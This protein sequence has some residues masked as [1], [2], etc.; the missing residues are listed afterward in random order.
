MITAEADL[1]ATLL[2]E[3][4]S[5]TRRRILATAERSFR[6]IGYQK[7]TVADIARA[8]RMSPANVYRFFESKKAINEAVVR[9]VMG[10]IEAMIADIACERRRPAGERIVAM[11]RALHADCLARCTDNPRMHEMCEAAMTES[12]DVCRHHVARI[13]D[14][15]VRVVEDGN[16]SG[17]FAVADPDTTGRCVHVALARYCHPLLVGQLPNASAPPVEAMADLLVAGLRARR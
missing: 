15:F 16:A 12:W 11:I 8:L 10:E 3:P 13:G 5:T 9:H 2:D 6:E 1:D 7:T 4:G 17:E 14:V